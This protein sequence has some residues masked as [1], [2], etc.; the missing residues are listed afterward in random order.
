MVNGDE[1]KA[2]IDWENRQDAMEAFKT[3]GGAR[4]LFFWILIFGLLSIQAVFWV[5]NCGM[6]DA[7]LQETE[8]PQE[9]TEIIDINNGGHQSANWILTADEFEPGSPGAGKLEDELPGKSEKQLGKAKSLHAALPVIVKAL[10]CILTF[11]SVLYCL[12]LLIG[13]KLALVGRLGGLADSGKAFFLS[14][15]VMVFIVPWQHA[16]SREIPAVLFAYGELLMSYEQ[17]RGF[18]DLLG[19]IVYYGRYVG[20]WFL[21]MVILSI[22]QWRSCRAVKSVQSRL[23]NLQ[24]SIAAVSEDPGG[25][26]E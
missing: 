14:L 2:N 8:R 23:D 4:S 13:M 5:V 3:F 26:V 19:N 9:D 21:T 12:S 6:V 7:V 16:I 1:M 24:K 18:D 17:N 15:L 20:F 22:T 25:S 11:T 10:N